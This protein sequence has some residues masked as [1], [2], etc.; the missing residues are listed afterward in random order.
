MRKL[1]AKASRNSKRSLRNSK[2]GQKVSLSLSPP[3]SFLWKPSNRMRI[4]KKWWLTKASKKTTLRKHPKN[5]TK[6]P[7]TKRF[8]TFERTKKWKTNMKFTSNS[9]LGSKEMTT[10]S[11]LRNRFLKDVSKWLK[12]DFLGKFIQL[13]QSRVRQVCALD[14]DFRLLSKDA[15]LLLTKA[16]ELF[17][18]DLAGTCGNVARQQKRKTMQVQDIV[19]VTS[20]VDKFHFI[21][22][23]KLPALNP[24]K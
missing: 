9:M 2:S 13:P 1:K 20:Y 22:D 4:S 21:K 24:R 10:R 3:I 5:G 14:D 6:C 23:S 17:V 8:P 11:T 19:S 15:L 12:L 7:K 16:T 18:T